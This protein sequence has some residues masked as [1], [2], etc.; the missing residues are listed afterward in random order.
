M[1][2]RS[3]KEELLYSAYFVKTV[4]AGIKRLKQHIAG[5][6]CDVEKCQDAPRIVRKESDDYMKKNSRT[7]LVNVCEGEANEEE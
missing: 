3:H 7:T 5:G 6:Y 4:P 1:V 2:A